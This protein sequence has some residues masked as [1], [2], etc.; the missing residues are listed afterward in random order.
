MK[1]I[2][3]PLIAD[4][5][6]L[7]QP[8]VQCL[9]SI[10]WCWWSRFMFT[11]SAWIELHLELGFS[12]VWR[13]YLLYIVMFL[14]YSTDRFPDL[15]LLYVYELKASGR[16]P[17]ESDSSP[18]CHVPARRAASLKRRAETEHRHPHKH[19]DT[20]THIQLVN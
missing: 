4:S 5:V 6:S 17:E 15:Q 8:R 13:F 7:E 2:E 1:D 19:T 14:H 10:T 11:G 12:L 18:N 9:P 3:N 16:F 20:H